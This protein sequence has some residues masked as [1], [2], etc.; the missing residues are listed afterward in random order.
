MRD[1]DYTALFHDILQNLPFAFDVN[2]TS[3]L[4]YYQQFGPSKECPS[5]RDSLSLTARKVNAD[6]ANLRIDFSTAK[7]LS[8]ADD[9]KYAQDV[10]LKDLAI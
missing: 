3:C 7:A 2:T 6:C 8:K 9:F 5:Q 10:I 1:E 4:I